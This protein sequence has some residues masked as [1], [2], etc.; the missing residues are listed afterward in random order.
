MQHVVWFAITKWRKL[1]LSLV[2]ETHWGFLKVVS[3]TVAGTYVRDL[4]Q[5]VTRE[6]CRE[7]YVLNIDLMR[8]TYAGL[9]LKCFRG[10]DDN[11]WGYNPHGS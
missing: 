11:S 5:G 3:Q 8:G 1:E 9:M 10:H 6:G 4:N 2:V 7:R